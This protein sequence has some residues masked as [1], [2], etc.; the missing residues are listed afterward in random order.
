M[1]GIEKPEVHSCLN[2]QIMTK[3]GNKWIYQQQAEP[4]PRYLQVT[5]SFEKS[6]FYEQILL[7][8]DCHECDI[9]S[10]LGTITNVEQIQQANG[11]T[12]HAASIAEGT[13]IWKEKDAIVQKCVKHTLDEGEGLL[14]KIDNTTFQLTNP[15][16]QIDFIITKVNHNQEEC[17]ISLADNEYWAKE[18]TEIVITVSVFGGCNHRKLNFNHY[19]YHCNYASSAKT[20]RTTIASSHL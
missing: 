6:C 15:Q 19:N 16:K 13:I 18:M 3:S 12:W 8:K 11:S 9:K 17:N 20:Y 14:Y 7:T 10:A 2:K 1:A 4:N 5:A